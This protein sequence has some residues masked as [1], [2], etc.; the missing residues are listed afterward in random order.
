MPEPYRKLSL[1]ESMWKE[2]ERIIKQRPE[3]GY[4]SVA[5]FVKDA[6]RK[7]IEELRKSMILES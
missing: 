3:L 4:T 1:P 6:I 2:I 7:R 5:E